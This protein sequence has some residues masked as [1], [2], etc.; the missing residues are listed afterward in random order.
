MV[1]VIRMKAISQALCCYKFRQVKYKFT[2]TYIP[3]VLFH[4][5]DLN[6]SSDHLT[7]QVGRLL[8]INKCE[9]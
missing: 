8:N 4:Q 2:V 6:I 3:L 1:S 5:F 7:G 9:K